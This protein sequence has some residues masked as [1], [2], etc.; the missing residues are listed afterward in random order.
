MTMCRLTDDERRVEELPSDTPM[1]VTEMGRSDPSPTNDERVA[2]DADD[3]S[4][5]IDQGVAVDGVGAHGWAV[6]ELI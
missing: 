5:H 4:W 3:A 1:V 2:S 6:T